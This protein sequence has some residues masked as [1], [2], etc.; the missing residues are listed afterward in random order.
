MRETSVDYI[1]GEGKLS[2]WTSDPKWIRKMQQYMA[3]Y[4]N[5]VKISFGDEEAMQVTCPVSWF[6]PPKPPVKRV[7]TEEQKKAAAD[8]MK[9][10]RMAKEENE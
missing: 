1:A 5:D 10:A 4:P 9:K 8:R 2:W 3:E 6:K 7:F